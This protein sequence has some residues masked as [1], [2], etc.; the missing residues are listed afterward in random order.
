MCGRYYVAEGFTNEIKKVCRKIDQTAI[1]NGDVTP[2]MDAPVILEENKEP[3]LAKSN[4]GYKSKH[5]LVINARAEG[6]LTTPMFATSIRT[7]RC[8]IPASGFYEWNKN[9]DKFQFYSFDQNELLYMAG[10]YRYDGMS[11]QH[12]II[13]TEANE[14]MSP[15]H[16][17]MPL[18]LTKEQLSQWLNQPDQTEPMLLIK[19]PQLDRYTENEQLEFHFT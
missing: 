5:G 19:P 17:R 2:A 14:S 12:V 6:V 1:R 13:T 9:K 16:N 3:V 15:V 11:C 7:G 8:I 4:W 18:I 10:I